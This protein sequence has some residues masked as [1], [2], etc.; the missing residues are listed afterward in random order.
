[1]HV[2]SAFRKGLQGG[3]VVLLATGSLH[4]GAADTYYRWTNERGHP[5]HSDRPP[6]NGVNYEVVSSRSGMKRVVSGEQGAV[7]MEVTSRTGNEFTPVPSKTASTSAKN[8]GLCAS[9]RNNLQ[10]IQNNARV[11]IRDDQGGMKYIN[12]EERLE[13]MNKNKSLISQYCD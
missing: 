8:P 10:T 5:V 1:M 7:P 13:L 4:V 3:M 9:A 11:Q 12:D 6:S 2:K